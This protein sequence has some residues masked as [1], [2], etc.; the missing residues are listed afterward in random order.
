H[1]PGDQGTIAGGWSL[2]ITTPVPTNGPPT[3][4]G[5]PANQIVAAGA[6]PTFSV[7]AS[8]TAL[9]YQWQRSSTNLPNGGNVSGATSSVLA[10]SNV[11]TNDAG[12]FRVVVAN[13]FGSV[14]SAVATLT[15]TASGNCLSPAPS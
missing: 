11:T 10:L 5:Q 3:I 6:N 2:T 14:T 1:G 15:V 9:S 12:N 8:G 4:S 13:G 7:T